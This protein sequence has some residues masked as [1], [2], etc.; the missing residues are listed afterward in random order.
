M[1]N[2]KEIVKSK[3]KVKA[4]GIG[5]DSG[6]K[7]SV[8]TRLGG[9]RRNTREGASWL[10]MLKRCYSK[11]WH[12]RHPSYIGCSVC[13]EWLDFQVF[14]EWLTTNDF[15][16]DKYQLD[17]D[18]LFSG[19]KVYSPETCVLIPQEI[20]KLLTD[21]RNHRG[22]HP[23]GVFWKTASGK[24][25]SQINIDGKRKHLGYFDCPHEAHLAYV[26]EKEAQ[27]KVVANRWKGCM[28]DSAYQALMDWTVN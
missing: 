17:K 9:K 12:E 18:I 28:E 13:L 24:Y 8:E 21:R 4:F 19:N 26:V 27:V 15:Y 3:P 22:E 10:N 14:A 6:G 1:Q 11:G 23:L 25:V 20:N 16:I 5:Y 7:F 2:D